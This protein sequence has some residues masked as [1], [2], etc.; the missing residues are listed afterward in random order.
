MRG[1]ARHSNRS[2][3]ARK[4]G[5]PPAGFAEKNPTFECRAA[6]GLPRGEA[7]AR[8]T[9]GRSYSAYRPLTNHQQRKFGLG[10]SANR[11]GLCKILCPKL[12]RD[13]PPH[14]VFRG[15]TPAGNATSADELLAPPGVAVARALR[16]SA[17][18]QLTDQFSGAR[19]EKIAP[20]NSLCPRALAIHS[21][22]PS[23]K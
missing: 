15:P 10:D 2:C 1:A 13:L 11:D 12:G 21:I 5:P 8:A 4:G 9:K 7:S 3:R 23:A 6:P 20:P 17:V 14:V 16:R 18:S 22:S 19:P